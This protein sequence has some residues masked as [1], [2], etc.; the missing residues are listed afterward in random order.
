MED[1][2]FS[3]ELENGHPEFVCK[4]YIDVSKHGVCLNNCHSYEFEDA[5]H[6]TILAMSYMEC[7]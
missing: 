7:A 4:K 6:A 5:L 3:L 2:A 1:N